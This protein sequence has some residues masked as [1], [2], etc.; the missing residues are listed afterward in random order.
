MA[1]LTHFQAELSAEIYQL[2]SGFD[3]PAVSLCHCLLSHLADPY[4]NSSKL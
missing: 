4:E 1:K 3:C 2:D